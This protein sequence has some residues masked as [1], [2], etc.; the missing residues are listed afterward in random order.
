MSLAPSAFCMHGT[1]VDNVCVCDA[2]WENDMLFLRVNHCNTIAGYG[3]VVDCITI[4]VSIACQ[5]LSAAWLVHS[6]AKNRH[7]KARM[8][9]WSAQLSAL[10]G[11]GMAA[12]HLA[13]GGPSWLF[14]MFLTG[15]VVNTFVSVNLVN[16][17]FFDILKRDLGKRQVITPRAAFYRQSTLVLGFVSTFLLYFG[18]VVMYGVR[19]DDPVF[20][21]Y[22][23][24]LIFMVQPV[25]NVF[26][27]ALFI[28]I[29]EILQVLNAT[30][31]QS[32]LIKRSRERVIQFR[33]VFLITLIS[34]W[35]G[36]IR[37]LNVLTNAKLKQGRGL[38]D[39]RF[40]VGKW[41]A[42]GLG[43]LPRYYD[44]YAHGE[45]YIRDCHLSPQTN[46]HQH[47]G[48]QQATSNKQGG[49]GPCVR[50][51]R[52]GHTTLGSRVSNSID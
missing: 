13:L 12:L 1:M 19:S 10:C 8:A 18:L 27:F 29:H 28:T 48:F 34:S 21:N 31:S 44:Y 43:Y 23:T 50:S 51:R 30:D 45:H 37:I 52:D 33:R 20:V 38:V 16:D 5:I 17:I 15:V 24:G 35:Y 36:F 42:V 39:G 40:D 9:M 7:W 25:C 3:L 22:V 32:D 11:I 2:G 41:G 46:Q 6:S 26:S 49:F 47:E 14:W 4:A